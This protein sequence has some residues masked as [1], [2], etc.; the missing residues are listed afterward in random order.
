M[1]REQLRAAKAGD[2]AAREAVGRYFARELR[3]LYRSRVPRDVA[4]VLLQRTALDIVEKFDE[5][6][7]EPAAFGRWVRGFG[8]ITERK[9]REETGRRGRALARFGHG[10]ATP[11][12]SLDSQLDEHRN[13]HRLDDAIEALDSPIRSTYRLFRAELSAKRVADIL[14]LPSSTVRSRLMV[15]RRRLRE[16]LEA[17]VTP[18]P[19][20]G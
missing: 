9:W 12:R 5:A 13:R 11:M 2:P 18:S 8:I 17:R 3:V 14:D 19:Y 10:S 20:R 15:A 6:P 7:E 16:M 4:S 1:D